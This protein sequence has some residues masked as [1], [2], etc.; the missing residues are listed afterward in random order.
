MKDLDDKEIVKE[1][2]KGNPAVLKYCYDPTLKYV[3][4]MVQKNGGSKD[5]AK[6][7]FHDALII[8]NNNCKKADFLLTSALSTYI[9]AICRHIWFN[10][11]KKSDLIVEEAILENTT[12][13]LH[14]QADDSLL[15]QLL[16]AIN[17]LGG[18]CKEI[19][20]DYY[21]GKRPYDE[22]AKDLG[23]SSGQVVRQQKYRCIQKL[24]NE[25]KYEHTG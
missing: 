23:Y 17:K 11:K 3:Q 7:I 4:S 5:E 19:L 6:D 10:Q 13:E 16:V 14:H 24:K 1:L 9:Y 8:L 2:K 20:L 18:K 15:D 25:F 21:Y 12:F 22:I